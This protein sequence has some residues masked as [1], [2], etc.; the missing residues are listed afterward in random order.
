MEVRQLSA[1]PSLVQEKQRSRKVRCKLC[2]LL[3]LRLCRGEP[4]CTFVN[5]IIG[6]PLALSLFPQVYDFKGEA[7]LAL[8]ERGVYRK[9]FRV[10]R[11]TD[12]GVQDQS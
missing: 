9:A 10:R 8:V 4:R 7:V 5:E 3:P 6:L 11:D 2:L 1:A 12:A